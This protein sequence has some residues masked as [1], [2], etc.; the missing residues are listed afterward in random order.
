LRTRELVPKHGTYRFALLSAVL[1]V[2]ALPRAPALF[3]RSWWIDELITAQVAT[4]PLLGPDFW[5]PTQKP[6]ASILGFT[7]QDTGPGPLTYL[8]EGLFARWAH[9]HGGEFW[10]RL[11][12][13]FAALLMAAIIFVF[14]K[15]WWGSARLAAV[16]ALATA[17]FPPWVDFSLGARG[18]MW[19]VLVLLLHMAALVG[20]VRTWPHASLW[21]AGLVM[22]ALST[23]AF[24]ITPINMVWCWPFW[25]GLTF[26][27]LRSSTRSRRYVWQVLLICALGAALFVI[28]YLYVWLVR[29]GAK[30][31]N[32]VNP[33]SMDRAL[34]RFH[35]F[36]SELQR[37]PWY[38]V[39]ILA[40]FAL[41]TVTAPRALHKP[42][43]RTPWLV[44]ALMLFSSVILAI[45]FAG[46]FFL[47][48]RY[49]VGLSIPLVWG[50][51]W[52]LQTLAAYT[53]R[54]HG[55]KKAELF[56]ALAA[57]C[58]ILIQLPSAWRVARTPVHDWLSAVRWLSKQLQPGD[59]VFCGPNADIE[60]L[61]AYAKPL[62]WNQQ[63]PRWLIVEGGRRV[64]TSTSEAI[65]RAIAAGSRLWFVTPFW[66]QIRPAAYW[67]LIRR[68][69]HEVARFCGRGDVVIYSHEPTA[70][71]LQ[72]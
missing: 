32:L 4:R 20:F 30:Q 34:A 53:R 45:V 24:Y 43:T 5:D 57:C 49:F 21:R 61:W 22:A 29:V 36:A 18:Y 31:N 8:V 60:V 50:S 59:I 55:R 69:F 7:L 68:N 1:V 64:D 54:R 47:A 72:Q 10:L 52:A 15:R 23:L 58:A 6:S 35:D 40:P 65:N 46:R 12:G 41:M 63:V 27:A 28:P 70:S 19:T 56:L 71:S 25:A 62:G 48:P 44:C 42:F 37:E 11:P 33:F 3:A 66:G 38:A 13:I 67:D 39:L 2:A 26:V 9:P 51:A 16:M 17:V 14:G